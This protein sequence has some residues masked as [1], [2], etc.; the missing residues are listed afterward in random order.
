M[1]STDIEKDERQ[2]DLFMVSWDGATRIQLTHT[3][4]DSESHPRFSPDGRYIAFLAA[5]GGEI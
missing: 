5:R 1:R 2:S 3:P 4:D